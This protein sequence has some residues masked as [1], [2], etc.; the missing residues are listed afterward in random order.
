MIYQHPLAYLLGLQGTALLRAFNG[1]YDREFTHARIAEIRALLDDPDPRLEA[2]AA[3]RPITAAEGYDAWAPSYDEPNDLIEI[4]E[5]VV[6]GILDGLPVGRALDAACGTGRHAAYLDS[7]G[8]QVLGVDVSANMLALA[9]AKVP[10]ADFRHG[11]ICQLPVPDQDVDLVVCALALTHVPDL[12]A[13]FAEFSRVLR[14]G[15]HLVIAD[16]RMDYRIVFRLPD[17]QYG[18]L[19]HYRR[20]TS[21]YLTTALALGLHVRYCEE[22]RHPWQDPSQVPTPR[23]DSPGLPPNIWALRDWCPAAFRAACNGSPLLIFWHFQRASQ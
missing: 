5:P 10:G 1:D 17:G 23:R 22:L 16:S 6:H 12:A 20:M 18:Y 8:H 2:A 3:A 11:D 15:G 9:R 7:L 13:A 4:E 21:E 14:P 19:P